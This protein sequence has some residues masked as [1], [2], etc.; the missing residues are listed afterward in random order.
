MDADFVGEL[1]QDPVQHS[2]ASS[3]AKR[4]LTVAALIGPIPRQT[5]TSRVVT[6]GTER[7]KIMREIH[8]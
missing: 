8:Q 2:A 4:S 1:G 7:L 6:K 3:C 5:L